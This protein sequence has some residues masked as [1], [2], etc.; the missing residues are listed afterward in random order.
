MNPLV[1]P[2]SWTRCFERLLFA[3]AFLSLG[4]WSWA[5][6][7]ASV[8]EMVQSRRLDGI[9]WGT[10]IGSS[11]LSN[12]RIAGATRREAVASGLIGRIEIPSIGV[13]AI[14]AEGTHPLVL[15]R[16]VGHLRKTAF[17]G[18]PG[19]VVVAGHRD[20]FFSNLGEVRPGDRVRISTP[21]GVFE[22]RVDS[23]SVVWPEQTEV[24]IATRAPTLTLITCYPF[25][26]L[27]PAPKRYIV[28]ARQE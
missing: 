18:E 6:L 22:Y 25:H 10:P 20:S 26:Y 14:V 17:P 9:L 16:A 23:K 28:R 12:G 27:G 21:D 5:R 7:D 8:Y 13:N 24:L 19:N 2:I 15:H 3:V 11:T 1:A 4:L